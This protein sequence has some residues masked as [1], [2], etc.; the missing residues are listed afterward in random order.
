MA[1]L[2]AKSRNK[3]TKPQIIQK[4][5]SRKTGASIDDLT[6][7]TG[8]QVHSIRAAVTGLRKQGLA[9]T[10]TKNAKGIGLYKMVSEQAND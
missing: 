1:K 9:I 4:L 5:I 10:L 3:L 2:P 7:A 6:K 8:W